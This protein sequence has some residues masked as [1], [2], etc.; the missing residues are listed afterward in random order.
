MNDAEMKSVRFAKDDIS[1]SS[2]RS[3]DES[4]PHDD[5]E[6]DDH[7]D[8]DDTSSDESVDE[9]VDD[10]EPAPPAP[11]T[12]APAARVRA[13]ARTG[14]VV[15]SQSTRV[16]RLDQ[17]S[18][19]AVE[20][21]VDRGSDDL[22]LRSRLRRAWAVVNSTNEPVIDWLAA[23]KSRWVGVVQFVDGACLRSFSQ[24]VFAN[25]SLS[26]LV[27]LAS[28]LAHNYV[29]GLLSLL[30]AFVSSLAAVVLGLNW[31]STQ[32][33][34]FGYN[35]VLLGAAIGNGAHTVGAQIGLTIVGALV[36]TILSVYIG[37]VL[38]TWR[39][40]PLTFPFNL[41]AALLFA[42]FRLQFAAAPPL[43]EPVLPW[44]AVWRGSLRGVAQIYFANS[45]WVGIAML[46][47]VALSSR[48]LA[49]ALLVGSA[50]GVGV[51]FAVG[52]DVRDIGDGLFS[53]NASLGCASIWFFYVI[54][55]RVVLL[56]LACAGGTVLLRLVVPAPSFTLPFCLSALAFLFL[57]GT[58][59]GL[60]S[61]RLPDLSTPE[62]HLSAFRRAQKKASPA[63]P[64]QP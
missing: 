24:V 22:S 32:T 17:E 12:P 58:A 43:A 41:S 61:V 1:S 2:R 23:R 16:R 42:A 59:S 40:A 37:V 14:Y 30:A 33:G 62:A 47:G 4:S 19:V 36:C 21:G 39:V 7:D 27:V 35:A 51:G 10:D 55:W 15:R 49:L 52:V 64:A 28:L 48:L 54:N 34:L 57:Q 63:E 31:G 18:T 13:K 25:N 8:D 46:L 20:A 38:S 5:D 9:R 29:H 50:V 53:F 6:D 56:G 11:S 60:F 3:S 26:G 45:E 44:D